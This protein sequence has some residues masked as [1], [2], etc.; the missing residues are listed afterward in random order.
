MGEEQSPGISPVK[1]TVYTPVEGEHISLPSGSS[2]VKDDASD[3]SESANVVGCPFAE[4]LSAQA[5]SGIATPL[6]DESTSLEPI[7]EDSPNSPGASPS[8]ASSAVS[9][10]VEEIEDSNIPTIPR[11]AETLEKAQRNTIRLRWLAMCVLDDWLRPIFTPLASWA[12]T[13][14]REE[15]IRIRAART[16]AYM[17]VDALDAK[18]KGCLAIL[19][20]SSQK[21]D[22]GVPVFESEQVEDGWKVHCKVVRRDGV[23][24]YVFRS[25]HVDGI[26]VIPIDIDTATD[27]QY[28]RVDPDRQETGT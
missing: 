2:S 28:R 8:P 21:G 14:L 16:K 23:E 3:S 4:L 10:A 17:D 25:S 27:M 12:M 15:Q 26:N 13:C 1:R 9:P 22:I 20:S 6:I 7:I 5:R 11:T 24:L 19:H 18:T